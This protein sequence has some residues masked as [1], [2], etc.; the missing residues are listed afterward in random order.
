VQN[1]NINRLPVE[2]NLLINTIQIAS[3]LSSCKAS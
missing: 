2:T 3:A 1:V